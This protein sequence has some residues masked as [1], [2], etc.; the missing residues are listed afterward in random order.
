M[1]S[2]ELVH[3]FRMSE[4]VCYSD[5]IV[6]TSKENCRETFRHGRV[7]RGSDIDFDMCLNWLIDFVPQETAEGSWGHGFLF[8]ESRVYC[9]VLYTIIV[10][11]LVQV[12]EERSSDVRSQS[13]AKQM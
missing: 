4:C 2:D 5:K 1:T 11:P 12:D 7:P 9:A 8:P 13:S 3:D 6:I 10:A